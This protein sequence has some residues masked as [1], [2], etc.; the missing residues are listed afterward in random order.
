M[1]AE[2]TVRLREK[3]E[4]LGTRI[5]WR[6][7]RRVEIL[8]IPP[9]LRICVRGQRFH[10]TS[11]ALQ[12]ATPFSGY[13]VRQLAAQCSFF[14]HPV[15]LQHKAI[16]CYRVFVKYCVFSRKFATSPTPELGCYWLYKKLPANGSDCTL[17]LC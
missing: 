16:L 10:V 14:P 17:A 6:D 15:S 5:D 11:L 1:N 4:R 3:R 8:R 7:G 12:P 9:I 2:E 13:I